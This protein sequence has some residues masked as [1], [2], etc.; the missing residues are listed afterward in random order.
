MGSDKGI[1]QNALGSDGKPVYANPGGTT[2]T[3]SGQANFDQWY[4]NVDGVNIPF[5][6]GLHFVQNGSVLTFAASIG[7]TGV[8]DSYYFPLDGQGWNDQGVGPDGKL[9]NF[10]FTT[11]I[12]TA[13]LYNGGE[14]FTFQGDDD[15]FVFING[16]LVIDLGGIHTQETGT[17]DLDAQASALGISTG[18]VYELAIFNAERHT[19]QSNFRVDT[20]L[21][22]TNCGN[23]EGVIY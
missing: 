22:F 3:T 6:L 15:V 16:R 9:H 7:N 18:N 13:F 1:V 8:P 20:T 10:A 14:T 5:V 19:S 11:E 17:V 4:R 23:V 12:H 21:A 2:R